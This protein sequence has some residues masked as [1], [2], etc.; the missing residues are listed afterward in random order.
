MV[1]EKFDATDAHLGGTDQGAVPGTDQTQLMDSCK[2]DSVGEQRAETEGGEVAWDT[3]GPAVLGAE[4]DPVIP[5]AE[6]EGDEG[7]AQREGRWAGQAGRGG[8][9]VERPEV[10]QDAEAGPMK[11]GQVKVPAA[12]QKSLAGRDCFSP[13]DGADS[14]GGFTG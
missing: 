3:G 7:E 10:E 11:Q 1:K 12:N 14:E 9:P 6:Q 13:V 8:E 5:E 2:R 4:I